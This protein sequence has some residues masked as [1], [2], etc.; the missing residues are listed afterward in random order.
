MTGRRAF[1]PLV[2][3]A[4]LLTGCGGWAD[5]A[6]AAE[7]VV[8]AFTAALAAGDGSTAC[9]LLMPST[10]QHLDSGDEICSRVIGIAELPTERPA[11]SAEVFGDAAQV[12]TAGDVLF[13]ATLDGEWR[14]TAAGCTARPDDRPY[15]CTIDGG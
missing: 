5:R 14:I 12:R 6:G 11:V 13:L 10:A 3:G 2:L 15:D 1:V 4:S 7:A 8:N 9:S